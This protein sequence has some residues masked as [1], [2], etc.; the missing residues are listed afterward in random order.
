MK[1]VIGHAMANDSPHF[2]DLEGWKNDHVDW[3]GAD[4]RKYRKLVT[5]VIHK[6]R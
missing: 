5:K 4:V 2:K 3:L 1:D 6:H